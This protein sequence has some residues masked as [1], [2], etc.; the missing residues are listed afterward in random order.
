MSSLECTIQVF[1][2]D[3]RKLPGHLEENSFA[4]ID[5]SLIHSLTV[6]KEFK[7]GRN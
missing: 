7:T 3:A 2:I 1:S 6:D 5:V 4:R